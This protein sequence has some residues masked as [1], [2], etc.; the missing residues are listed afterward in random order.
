M[1]KIIHGVNHTNAGQNRHYIT[2]RKLVVHFPKPNSGFTIKGPL[3]TV[4]ND[5]TVTSWMV[6]L[7]YRS[8]GKQEKRVL[9]QLIMSNNL[10]R[11]PLA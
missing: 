9:Q 3:I 10:S 4:A 11:F 7:K 8:D 6:A 1:Y 5:D 2:N